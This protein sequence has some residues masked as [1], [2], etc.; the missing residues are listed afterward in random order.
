MNVWIGRYIGKKKQIYEDPLTETSLAWVQG[1]HNFLQ[2]NAGAPTS[3]P[4]IVW[5]LFTSNSGDY[6][7]EY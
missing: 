7:N 1:T 4:M 5:D 3:A 2:A 6:F